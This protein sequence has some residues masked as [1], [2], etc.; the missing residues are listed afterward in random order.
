MTHDPG[1]P[2][3]LL[4][5]AQ[6]RIGTDVTCRFC[7]YNLR[8]LLPD[9]LCPE[10]GKP[11][12]AS[13]YRYLL[14]FADPAWVRSLAGG[15]N[16]ILGAVLVSVGMLPTAML[17]IMYLHPAQEVVVAVIGL[18]VPGLAYLIGFWKLTRPQPG[19]IDYGGDVAR[20]CTRASAVCVLAGGL[21][22]FPLAADAVAGP[23][24][25]IVLL[26]AVVCLIVAASRHAARLAL[27]L[28][29]R[30]L[31]RQ[32]GWAMWAALVLGALFCTSFRS[33]LDLRWW[34]WATSPEARFTLALAAWCCIA[35]FA[36]GLAV[37]VL[38]LV[39]G[40]RE[41]LGLAA[42]RAVFNHGHGAGINM[43]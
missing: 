41:A 42:S 32:T 35:P 19:K 1:V 29:D 15:A 25:G 9:G 34:Y 22:W 24:L 10:C 17:A 28:P 5:D 3:T 18:G 20:V 7:G 21:A 2:S 33:G 43:T 16:W 12:E 37:F 4:P 8:G 36:L 39:L 40:Y 26:V 6:G 30:A 11:V 13:T 31:A 38:S 27:R 23:L 14:E